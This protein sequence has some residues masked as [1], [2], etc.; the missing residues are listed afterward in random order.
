MLFIIKEATLEDLATVLTFNS[1]ANINKETEL[2]ID[3]AVQLFKQ[4]KSYPDYTLFIIMEENRIV[5]SFSLLIMD[6]LAHQGTPSGIIDN[7]AI[8]VNVKQLGIRQAMLDFSIKYCHDRQCYKLTLPSNEFITDELSDFEHHGKC[9]VMD[10]ENKTKKEKKNISF[11]SIITSLKIREATREDL[12]EILD[13]YA[14]PGMDDGSILST[15]QA[16]IMYKKMRSYPNYKIFACLS[17]GSIVGTFAL[18]IAPNL[19]HNGNALAII[20]DVMVSPKTQGKGIGKFMMSFAIHASEE[21]NCYKMA[22]SSNLKREMAHNFY[23]SLGFEE[24]GASFLIKPPHELTI[25]SIAA[26]I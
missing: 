18:L 13:L 24:I 8:D 16:T 15:L 6:N 9:F 21:L 20:E 1:Q 17:E 12:P 11:L 2:S 3:T 5:G 4:M 25:E 26:K 7:L 22:L 19:I 14:Q 10:F 23:K